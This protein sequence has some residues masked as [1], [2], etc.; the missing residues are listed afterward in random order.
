[1]AVLPVGVWLGLKYSA[2]EGKWRYADGQEFHMNQDW[3]AWEGGKPPPE[4]PTTDKCVLLQRD[5][6]DAPF[7]WYVEDCDAELGLAVCQ[8][9]AKDAVGMN[10]V[11]SIPKPV[12]R[13]NDGFFSSN[14]RGSEWH[15]RSS[16]GVDD[17]RPTE[18][19]RPASDYRRIQ[20]RP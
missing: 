7:E 4:N 19:C 13:S 20:W 9:T 14:S 18:E 6:S 5:G 2:A 15:W 8:K 16:Y 12:A 11:P 10:K 1:M 3:A 17:P